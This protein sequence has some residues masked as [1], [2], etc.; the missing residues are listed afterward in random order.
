MH[1]RGEWQQPLGLVIIKLGYVCR[2]KEYKMKKCQEHMCCAA[3]RSVLGLGSEGRLRTF[4]VVRWFGIDK[5]TFAASWVPKLL[6][7]GRNT[8]C[9]CNKT[10]LASAPL[11]LVISV[12]AF[13]CEGKQ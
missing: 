9:I 2:Y 10:Y 4:G 1:E 3:R 8:I 12:I 5:A 6:R 13:V 11:S 7:V